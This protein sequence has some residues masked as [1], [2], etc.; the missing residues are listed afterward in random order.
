MYQCAPLSF[1]VCSIFSHPAIYSLTTNFALKHKSHLISS[2]RIQ[3]FKRLL[4]KA[5][6]LPVIKEILLEVQ[7]FLSSNSRGSYD[8]VMDS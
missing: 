1:F 3:N 4:E 2:F 8:S 5:S 7:T 6:D